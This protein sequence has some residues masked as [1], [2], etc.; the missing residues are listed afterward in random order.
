MCLEKD[1][2]LEL[3]KG[4]IGVLMGCYWCA[5]GCYWNAIVCVPLTRGGV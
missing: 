5:D 4:D 3:L 1:I 2:C